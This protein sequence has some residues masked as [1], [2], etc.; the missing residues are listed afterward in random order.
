MKRCLLVL[1]IAFNQLA[2]AHPDQILESV[3]YLRNNSVAPTE[4]VLSKFSK[5]DVVL[6]GEDHAVK[7]NLD[8]VRRL[9]P[10]LYRKGV[11]NLGME[12]GSMETQAKIDSLM[13][14]P[15]YNEQLVRDVMYF[16]N[17]A[18][19]YADYLE[20]YRAVWEFNQTL[21]ENQKKFR[22][23]HLSYQYDWKSFQGEMTPEKRRKV[24]H[25]GGD[26]FWS[27]RV[28]GEVIS[29]NEKILC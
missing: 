19:P 1:L 10:A 21:S 4:Y 26:K 14:A 25:R 15:A 3:N 5:H 29:R 16:H 2:D 24:F 18:W 6:L 22:I 11:T 13:T 23:L 28:K 27:D 17:V 7:D 12:F 9:V 20:V 8:F